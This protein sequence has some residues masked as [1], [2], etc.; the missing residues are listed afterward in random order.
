VPRIVGDDSLTRATRIE[1]PLSRGRLAAIVLGSIAFVLVSVSLWRSADDL[2][3][4]NA[5][6]RRTIAVAGGVFFGLCGVTACFK[7]FDIRP[8]L[9]L[10]AEGIIDNSSA[11]SAGRIAWADVRSLRVQTVKGRP[12]LTV[13]V[14]DPEKYIR[15]APLLKRV[16]VR[17]NAEFFGGPIH[18]SAVALRMNFDELA[19][20]VREFHKKQR[21]S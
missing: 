4:V 12:V 20:T 11:I 16:L 13:E 9:V 1:V 15:R 2:S 14:R 17:L 3:R 19:A 21:G 6:Y 8:G 18:I 5:I 7:L 10:D